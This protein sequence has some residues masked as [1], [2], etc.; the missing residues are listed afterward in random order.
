MQRLFRAITAAVLVLSVC[1]TASAVTI[2]FEP[3]VAP[4]G[5]P[6]AGHTE[7]GFTVKS[8]TANWFVAQIFGNPVPDIFAGP[9][10]E[11]TTSTI[12]VTQNT[13]GTFTFDMVDLASNNGTSSRFIFNGFLGA[14]P[15]F[16]DTGSFPSGTGPF[17]FTTE[18]NSFAALLIDR[19]DITLVPGGGVTSMNLDNIVVTSTVPEP[20][21][22]LLLG[23]GL[24][25]GVRRWRTRQRDA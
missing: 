22:L 4:N 14:A 5:T 1:G 23:A 25:G 7:A 10:G 13:L 19:L 15:V 16:T 18:S 21:S 11:V 24:L 3:L 20:A 6:Y 9:I 8:L 2:T 17:F 12:E